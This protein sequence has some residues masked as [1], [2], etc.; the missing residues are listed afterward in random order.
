MYI[1][2]SILLF[3]AL[4]IFLPLY[5]VRMRFIRGESLFLKERLGRQLSVFKNQKESI[6]IHAVSVG[7]VLSLQNLIKQI[8]KKHPGWTIHF[9][10]LTNT[11]I[12]VANDKLKEADHIFFAPLD[13]SCIVRRFFKSLRPDVFLLAE[14]EFWPNLLRGA[15]RWTRGVALINGRISDRSFNRYKKIRPLAK[16]VLKNIEVFLVQT[17]KDK[18]R[19]E[20]IGKN[21]FRIEAVGNLKSEIELPLLKEEEI[22]NLKKELRITEGKKVIVAGSTR[23]GEE[24]KLLNAFA[25]AKEVKEDI[26]LIL[27]PR[28]PQRAEEVVRL[29]QHCGLSTQR[30]TSVFQNKEWDVLVIDTLGELPKFYALAD[31]T[32]VG[33]SLIPWG[34]H[35]LLEPAF[36]KK[37][38]FFGPHMNNFSFLAK[39]FIYSQAAQV[40]EDEKDLVDMFLA[41]KEENLREMGNKAKKTLN[42][43]QGAT[44]KTIGIIEDLMQK[45]RQPSR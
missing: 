19:L 26:L 41:K 4:F 36:Y 10:S 1:F 37:P 14:S 6:W 40:I 33:G 28:H 43:L 2:Y 17:E 24:E 25:K 12:R 20:K 29:S 35:N 42:S 18:K 5:F 27:V 7:E 31:V 30:R 21:V 16:K 9:S 11:G 22:S 38:I 8:K 44:E 34:G 13:F 15:S 45:A 32:F 3:L 23:R 39:K